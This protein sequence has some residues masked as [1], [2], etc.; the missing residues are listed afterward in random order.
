MFSGY[1]KTYKS[2]VSIGLFLFMNVPLLAA[3][4][5]PFILE[6]AKDA[7]TTLVLIILPILIFLNYVLFSNRYIIHQDRLEIKSGIF[8]NSS[9][10]ISQ[11]KKLEKSNSL[12]SSPAASL[13]R[14][15]IL[16]NK[17]DS[18][19]ISPENKEDFIADLKQINPDIII[20][21]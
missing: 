20:K 9:I 15:E 16:Y 4:F 7:K 8:N 18:V 10:P 11:I 13:D 12:W 21:L 2:K 14:L 17:W 5:L 1:M 3:I 6:D 19:L